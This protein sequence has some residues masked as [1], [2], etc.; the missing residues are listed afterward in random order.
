KTRGQ[1]VNLRLTLRYGDANSLKG[2][3]EAADLLPDLMARATKNLN[4][5]QLADA[6]DKAGA[7]LSANGGPGQMTFTL[8][9]KRDHLPP[10]LYHPLDASH[11]AL[12][13]VGD[14]HRD[15]VQSATTTALANCSSPTHYQRITHHAPPTLAKVDEEIKTPDRANAQYGAAFAF[16]ISD[17]HPD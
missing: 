10:A 4:R 17:T 11:I 16:P 1:T 3:V 6:L 5:Q 8:Q 2:L 15:T 12:V 7:S 13:V 14:F 9:T